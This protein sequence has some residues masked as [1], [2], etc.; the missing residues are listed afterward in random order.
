M[1]RPY[2]SGVVAHGWNIDEEL[3]VR[4]SRLVRPFFGGWNAG[5]AGGVV[6]QAH[7]WVLRQP[8]GSPCGE[9]VGVC[10]WFE[11][12]SSGRGYTRQLAG[13]GAHGCLV[14]SSVA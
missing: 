8:A 10:F 9:G 4:C 6:R 11:Y 14:G 5:G 7:C 3:L 2:A 12:G 1:L 13:C